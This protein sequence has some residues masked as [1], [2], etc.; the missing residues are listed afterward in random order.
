MFSALR[1]RILILLTHLEVIFVD[2]DQRKHGEEERRQPNESDDCVTGS[3]TKPFVHPVDAAGDDPVTFNSQS[4]EEPDC[5]Q[6]R[7]KTDE[8]VHLADCKKDVSSCSKKQISWFTNNAQVRSQ[9]DIVHH[10]DGNL[11]QH[12]DI[13]KAQVNQKRNVFDAF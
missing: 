1:N 12:E 10:S 2:S 6:A 7:Q 9:H 5:A 4:R 8:S 13:G 11:D 3:L